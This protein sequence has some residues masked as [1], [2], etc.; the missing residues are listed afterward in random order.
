ML[1]QLS[2]K[3]TKSLEICTRPFYRFDDPVAV[4]DYFSLLDWYR[5]HGLHPNE[6]IRKHWDKLTQLLG[7]SPNYRTR[8]EYISAVWGLAVN[9][10]QFVLYSSFRGL[11]IQTKNADD[12]IV[13]DTLRGKLLPQKK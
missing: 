3:V 11:S 7:F 8:G 6:H 9:E 2:N 5:Q 1:S 12:K 13:I 10:M 4:A